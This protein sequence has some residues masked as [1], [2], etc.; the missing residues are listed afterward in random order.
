[1]SNEQFLV[2]GLCPGMRSWTLCVH[3]NHPLGEKF[4][5][6]HHCPESAIVYCP[7]SIIKIHK[8]QMSL[9][10]SRLH[11]NLWIS[12]ITYY[13]LYSK[14]VPEMFWGGDDLQYKYNFLRE[15]L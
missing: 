1:M 5:L 12:D 6:S 11:L 8:P 9:I 10:E 15:Q 14:P 3:K 4:N 7:S 2:P 13:S